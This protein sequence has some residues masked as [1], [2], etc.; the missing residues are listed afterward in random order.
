MS[1]GKGKND[2]L[3]GGDSVEI[4]DLPERSTHMQTVPTCAEELDLPP[5]YSPSNAVPSATVASSSVPALTPQSNSS[6]SSFSSVQEHA[7]LMAS[8]GIHRR[9]SHTEQP[10]KPPQ[11][12]SRGYQSTTPMQPQ[13]WDDQAKWREMED[14]PGAC[15][16]DS[17]GCL[18]SSHGGCCFSDHEG[19]CFSDYEGCCFSSTGGCFFS[20]SSGCCFSE[21]GGCF[22]SKTHGCCFASEG[23]CC[24]SDGP[25]PRE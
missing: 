1:P 5:P 6:R 13:G 25:A 9:N 8:S 4:P 15:C 2:G 7:A 3:D 20:E 16:S 17:G 11:T 14:Q 18:G 23:A 10:L 22:F 12:D 21:T 19:C 24:C